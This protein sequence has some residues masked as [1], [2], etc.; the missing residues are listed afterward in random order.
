MSMKGNRGRKERPEFRELNQRRTNICHNLHENYDI[1]RADAVQ[2]EG[3]G[4]I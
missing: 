2:M 1:E 3:K 4:D